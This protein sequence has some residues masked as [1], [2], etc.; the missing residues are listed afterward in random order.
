MVGF[1]Q[2][3]LGRDKLEDVGYFLVRAVA[4]VA[5]PDF[6]GDGVVFGADGNAHDFV[7]VR[8][9]ERGAAQHHGQFN[10]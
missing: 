9:N 4:L 3:R 7:A 2:D 8:R 6:D 1:V 10:P 5:V